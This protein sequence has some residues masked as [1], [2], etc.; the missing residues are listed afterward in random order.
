MSLLR[1]PALA[2]EPR[3]DQC[4]PPQSPP[5][6]TLPSS[7]VHLLNAEAIDQQARDP[8]PYPAVEERPD[9]ADTTEESARRTLAATL[10]AA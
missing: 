8:V 4:Q 6:I 9:D 1:L 5:V 7:R 2:V 10:T 3:C